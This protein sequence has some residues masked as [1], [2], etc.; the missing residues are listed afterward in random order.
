MAVG[1]CH[2]RAAHAS[3][4]TSVTPCGSKEKI[5]AN[6]NSLYY[7]LTSDLNEIDSVDTFSLASSSSSLTLASASC[8]DASRSAIATWVLSGRG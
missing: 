7:K 2:F 5:S 1:V 3:H 6:A 8:W 4:S